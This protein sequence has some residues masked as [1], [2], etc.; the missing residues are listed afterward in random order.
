MSLL[1]D[2]IRVARRTGLA[3]VPTSTGQYTMDTLRMDL[4]D[5]AQETYGMCQA[6]K[7]SSSAVHQVL[8]GGQEGTGKRKG[9]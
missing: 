6:A 8:F 2:V 7:D 1:D 4:E 3:A 9:R 5:S